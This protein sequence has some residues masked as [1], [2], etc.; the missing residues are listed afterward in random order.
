[1]P[2][3]PWSVFDA[4]YAKILV[5]LQ[6]PFTLL[7]DRST[8]VTTDYSAAELRSLLDAANGVQKSRN[9]RAAADGLS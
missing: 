8:R 7:G 9:D 6:R 3:D 1:M 4:G 5:K 2:C